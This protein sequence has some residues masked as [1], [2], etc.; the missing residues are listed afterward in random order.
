MSALSFIKLYV[1]RT[2]RVSTGQVKVPAA[3]VI[4]A[5]LV[6]AKVVASKSLVVGFWERQPSGS[7]CQDWRVLPA[8]SYSTSRLWAAAINLAA[9]VARERFL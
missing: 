3:A 6:Y 8:R 4:P 9:V 2:M 7:A 1:K 5:Q